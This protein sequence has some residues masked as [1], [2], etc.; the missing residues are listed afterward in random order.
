MKSIST[1]ART[2]RL[3][4]PLPR[5]RARHDRYA[6]VDGVRVRYVEAGAEHGGVPLVIVHGYNGSCDYWYPHTVLGLAERRHVIAVDLPGNGLSGKLEAHNMETLSNFLVRFV[7]TLGYERADLMGHS[8]GGLLAVAAANARPE[9]V[10][11]LVLVDSAGLPDLVKHLWLVPIVALADSSMRQWRYYPTFIKIGMRART[12][13]ECLQMVSRA[14]MRELLARLDLPVS[15][16]W[17]EKDRVVPVGHGHYMAAHIKGARL[18]VVE[19][20]GHM[21]FYEKPA[22]CNRLILDFIEGLEQRP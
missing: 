6:R 2:A 3:R 20:V 14:S 15:I 1:S 16:H 9:R 21:P 13:R 19:G 8:M 18:A 5:S 4:L 17:G 22:E 10:R 11:S 7:E 12:K